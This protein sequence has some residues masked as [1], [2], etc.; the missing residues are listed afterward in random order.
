MPEREKHTSLTSDRQTDTARH[1]AM[2]PASGVVDTLPDKGRDRLARCGSCDRLRESKEPDY[3]VE[4]G[5]QGHF[6]I[7][8]D[9]LLVALVLGSMITHYKHKNVES[10]KGGAHAHARATEELHREI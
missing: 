7:R 9:C 5:F 10:K 3:E 2:P 1:L 8:V 4:K 6:Q